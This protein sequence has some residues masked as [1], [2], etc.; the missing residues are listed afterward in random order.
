MGLDFG[1]G[2]GWE[3]ERIRLAP[4]DASRHFENS[5]RWVN[6]PAVTGSLMIGWKPVG[7]L[8]QR[9]WFDRAER[10]GGRDVMFAIEL[11]DGT[12]IGNSGLHGLDMRNGTATT[13]TLIGAVGEWGKGYGTEASQLRAWY[14]FEV[15]G[16][17]M[18]KSGFFAGNEGSRRM[19]EK[20]GYV[21]AG[22]FPE[23]IWKEGRYVDHVVTYLS[24]ERWFELSRGARRY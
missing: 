3:S 24:R 4:L 23:E 2:F 11:L 14:S 22:V 16:L 21:V 15:L 8:A 17:R 6:D 1:M 7:R 20:V 10:G 13:G 18:L 12:H 19:Q 9:E 5:Y